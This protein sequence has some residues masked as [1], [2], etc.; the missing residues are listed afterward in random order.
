MFPRISQW[1]TA[2]RCPHRGVAFR[3]QG[4]TIVETAI[5]LPVFFLFVFVI[6]EFGH[7][8]MV[9]NVLKNAA[10]SSARWGS[11]GETTTADVR[12]Y[13]KDRM[14]GAVD[15]ER[16]QIQI[17]DASDMDNGGDAPGSLEDFTD[18]PDLELASAERQQL[19]MVRAV[20]RYGDIAI[21]PHPWLQ[22]VWVGG[23]TF[24]RHE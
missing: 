21:L 9:S 1:F 13:A 4:T 10:R 7:A 5:V 12:Q 22:D 2:P 15:P 14:G 18:M 20:V 11:V 8:M 3:R 23:Q 24:T 6:M 17:K 19:F 16:V